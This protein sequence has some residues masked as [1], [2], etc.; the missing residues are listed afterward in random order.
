MA[1]GYLTAWIAYILASLILLLVAWRLFRRWLS[2]AVL[3]PI[4][5]MATVLLLLPA[6]VQMDDSSL[7]PAIIIAL[8]EFA[9]R[10]EPLAGVEALSRLLIATLAVSACILVVTIYRRRK[11]GRT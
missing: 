7:A 2:M 8:L 11:L 6:R 3:G 4:L 5:V 9:L 1:G 10:E